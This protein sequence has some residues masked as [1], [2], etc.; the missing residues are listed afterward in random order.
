M[1]LEFC[2]ADARPKVV[3]HSLRI[4]KDLIDDDQVEGEIREAVEEYEKDAASV[5]K[6]SPSAVTLRK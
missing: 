5:R 1:C 6:H 3:L 4:H 2:G